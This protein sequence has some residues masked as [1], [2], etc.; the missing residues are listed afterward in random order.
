MGDFPQV[1]DDPKPG[2][3]RHAFKALHDCIET[4]ETD[5]S[6]QRQ[7]VLEEVAGVSRVADRNSGLIAVIQQDVYETGQTID[8]VKVTVDKYE[9]VAKTVRTGF[10]WVVG[11]ILTAALGVMVQNIWQASTTA[12]TVRDTATALASS[13]VSKTQAQQNLINEQVLGELRTLSSTTPPPN[14]QKR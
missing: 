7:V 13:T 14:G 6:R 2:E 12:R 8:K 9:G 11:T 5:A 1:P 4:R 3:I 10:L